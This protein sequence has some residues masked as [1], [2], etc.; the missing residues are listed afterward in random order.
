MSPLPKVAIIYLTYPTQNWKTDVPRCLT[1]LESL[2]YPKDRVELICVESK[3]KEDP[4]KPWFDEH[5][6]PK[7]NRTLPPI[8]YVFHDTWIGFAGNNNIGYELARQK[9][10]EY[11]YLLNE[12]TDVDPGFLKAAVMRAEQD[13]NVAIVQ[14]LLKLG[15]ERDQINT[16]GNAWHLLGFG[17]SNGYHW[18]MSR[19]EAWLC[20]ERKTNPELQIA[21]ASGAGMLARIASLEKNGGLFDE[22][23]F[24]YHEDTDASLRARIQGQ[25]VVLE[26]SSIVYHHYAFNKGKIN[27]YWMERNRYVLVL[28]YYKLWTLILLSPF[29]LAFEIGL[30]GFSFL[31]G[32]SDMK[33]KAT[34]EFFSADFWSWI[35]RRRREMQYRRTISDRAFLERST[36]EIQFQ[37]ESVQNPLLEKV[38]NPLMA[39]Y[40]WVIQ[41]LLPNWA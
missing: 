32:W 41:R 16:I 25:K 2:D 10:C 29:F 37:E 31:R 27:Y 30:W 9:G 40:W 13:P 4:I 22:K 20:Q 7:S 39:G 14:S 12:D 24:L 8:T 26:P 11:V 36:A 6:M 15:Q 5:W 17:Y 34:K 21:Y 35:S 1:S 18:T 23:F 3:A 28:I 38:A 33:W 19:F